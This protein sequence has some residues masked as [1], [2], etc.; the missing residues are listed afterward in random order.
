MQRRPDEPGRLRSRA[1]L[2]RREH[3][4]PVEGDAHSGIA[5]F[6]VAPVVSGDESRPTIVNQGYVTPSDN[7]LFP[8]I[9]VN[10]SGRA[11]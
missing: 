5:C 1:P 4:V 8:S 10:T 6:M 3:R 2:D 11:S 7:V 9:G